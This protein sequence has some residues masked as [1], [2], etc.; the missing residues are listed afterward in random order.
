MFNSRYTCDYNNNYIFRIFNTLFIFENRAFFIPYNFP[1]LEARPYFEQHEHV[2]QTLFMNIH[3][4]EQQLKDSSNIIMHA[5]YINFKCIDFKYLLLCKSW[6]VEM[7]T[8]LP[9]GQFCFVYVIFAQE[10]RWT[11]LASCS[12][13]SWI[14]ALAIPNCSCYSQIRTGWTRNV[15]WIFMNIHA[16]HK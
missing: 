16:V 7:I 5:Y 3:E 15:F 13:Y 12:R 6:E 14:F 11:S 1:W 10:N 2:Q 4:H 8:G 9:S